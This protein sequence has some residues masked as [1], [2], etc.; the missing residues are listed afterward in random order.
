MSDINNNDSGL[1]EQ[2]QEQATNQYSQSED[3]S[4]Y[5]E[6]SEIQSSYEEQVQQ[7]NDNNANHNQR[8]DNLT[9]DEFKNNQYELQQKKKSKKKPLIAILIVLALL[10][11][12]AATA[13]AFSDTVRNSVDL[14]L[15][16]PRDYYVSV[17]NKSIGDSVDKSLAYTDM[18]KVDGNKAQSLNATLSY[19]KD[20]VGAMLQ[21]YAGMTISDLEALIGI[22]LDSIGFDVIAA[23]NDNGGYQKIGLNLNNIDIISGEIFIDYTLEQMLIHIPDLSPAYLKQSLDMS[24][25]GAEG[26]D[27]D[28][29][30]ASIK[31]IISDSTADFVKRYVKLITDEITDVE[32]KKNEQLTVGDITAEANLLTVYFYPETLK[33]ISTKVLEE[34]KNDEYILD[35]LP[36]FQVSKDDYQEEID[37][38]IEEAKENLDSLPQDKELMVMNVYVANDGSILGRKIEILDEDDGNSILGFFYVEDSNKGAYD[39]YI[40]NDDDSDIKIIGSHTKENGAYS[41]SLTFEVTDA[42][43]PIEFDVDYE[44]LKVEAKNGQMY[45]YGS[46]SISSYA[47]MGMEIAFEF[48]VKDDAQ[49]SAIKLNMG[50]SSLVT[51][52]ASTKY[53]K[54]FA[55]PKPDANAET[56]DMVTDIDVYSSTIDFE[57][58]ISTLSDRL[59]VDLQGLLGNLL[60]MY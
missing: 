58:F 37:E 17:E 4:T 2:E 51:L 27:F 1:P 6:S 59:G 49:V 38:A 25:Y 30:S 22:P 8:V 20:T 31:K 29:L 18:K 7:P 48:D 11:A 52:E 13:Y 56:Y 33:N 54:D 39:L 24:L 57:G 41:G 60:P 50:K 40:D 32:L 26:M 35:L 47:L 42:T 53:I 44:G 34:A 45:T 23:E 28:K 21:T 9:Y 10:I 55:I 46:F 15:K 19:D 12:T 3:G 36:L 5:W 14:L 16:S 43:G